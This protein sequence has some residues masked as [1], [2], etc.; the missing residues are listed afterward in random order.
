MVFMVLTMSQ[1]GHALA[2]RSG[3]ESLFKI[4]LFSN[5]AMLGAVVLTLVL[6]LAVTY[7]GPLQDIFHTTGLYA[8]DL[9]ISLL[10]SSVVFW[11]V[12]ISKWWRA[13]DRQ[14]ETVATVSA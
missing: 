14:N 6:Q 12:E 1:M 9:T 4:G 2:T 3:R 11:C 7:I 13:R 5:K 10:L 8:C